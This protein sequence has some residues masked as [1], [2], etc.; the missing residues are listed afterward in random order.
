MRRKK[1]G[2]WI[3]LAGILL[4]VLALFLIFRSESSPWALVVLGLSVAANTAAICM[5]IWK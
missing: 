1:I 2:V 4:L 5:I 3:L